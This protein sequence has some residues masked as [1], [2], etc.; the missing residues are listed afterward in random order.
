MSE[1]R[2]ILDGPEASQFERELLQS[3][4]AEQP[5]A[6]SRARALAIAGAAAGTLAAAATAASAS[7]S[8][9]GSAIMTSGSGSVGATAG[10]AAPGA[11]GAGLA[12]TLKWGF[13]FAFVAASVV[14]GVVVLGGSRSSGAPSTPVPA[15]IT[16]AST[17]PGTPTATT[18]TTTTTTAGPSNPPAAALEPKTFS[19]TELPPATAAA[20]TASPPG[21][22]APA[23]TSIASASPVAPAA[24]S[25]ESSLSEQIAS[26]DRARAA[27]DAGD[28][29]R[30]IALVDAYEKRFPTGTFVQEAEVLRIQALGRKGDTAGAR[31][32]GQR[33][34]AAHPTS[35]HAARIRAILDSS[36]P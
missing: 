24:P 36:S 21:A 4:A 34:L 16:T 10:V 11:A 8:A 33:F 27:F 15:L 31:R 30:V 6:A 5:S 20:A 12:V 13:L 19:P 25:A 1:P 23:V 35:P 9:S 18:A 28:H 32:A 3:W 2:R 14:A 7:A 29:D 26:F 17:A 22:R